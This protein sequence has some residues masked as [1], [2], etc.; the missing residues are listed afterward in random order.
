MATSHVLVF[1]IFLCGFLVKLADALLTNQ[2]GI[3]T[4]LQ[5]EE[6]WES[7]QSEL[8]DDIP[9]EPWDL[10]AE[11]PEDAP[12]NMKL[13]SHTNESPLGRTTN[14]L[15][16]KN[17]SKGFRKDP[18]SRVLVLPEKK[19]AFCYIEK[20]ACT[21][22]NM[23]FNTLNN[24]TDNG[25][26]W[27]G[28]KY[29]TW[30][31]SQPW[32]FGLNLSDLTAENGWKWAVFLRDPASR[33]VSAWGSKCLQQEDGGRNCVPYGAWAN[34]SWSVQQQLLSF[35]AASVLNHEN[36][37]AMALNPHWANQSS[38]CGGLSDLSK[39]DMVGR[40][41]G[42]VNAKVRKMLRIAGANESVADVYFPKN[43]VKGH[44]SHLSKRTFVTKSTEKLVKA[45]YEPDFALFESLERGEVP[46]L[47]S[48]RA[49]IDL[50]SMR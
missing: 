36:R 42:D 38:F 27:N 33:Y 4:T 3:K 48:D 6:P 44:T 1:N 25:T 20:V 17:H 23:L 49:Q 50:R 34:T 32:H 2:L 37:S 30:W 26:V 43:T 21:E 31:H 19:L 18:T 22:F 14:N 45:M 46:E 39:F 35:Q 47:V 9:V 15:T 13:S 16:R 12:S 41:S 5:D 11:L 8:N 29:T 7:L 24:L 28:T 40:L 10:S